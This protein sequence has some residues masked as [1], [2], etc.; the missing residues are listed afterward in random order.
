M[1]GSSVEIGEPAQRPQAGH[2]AVFAA[3]I[4]DES[5][6]SLEVAVDWLLWDGEFTAIATAHQRVLFGGCADEP[7]VVYPL[8]LDELELP[9][10]V[11]PDK[12]E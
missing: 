6:Q 9:V 1:P 8:P 4:D 11:R 10:K 2:E 7:A 12:G 3:A 5:G